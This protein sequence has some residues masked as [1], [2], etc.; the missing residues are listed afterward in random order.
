MSL[1]DWRWC[2]CESEVVWDR[3]GV[4]SGVAL[5]SSLEVVFWADVNIRDR[6]ER[7]QIWCD[8]QRAPS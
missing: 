6:C 7:A 1:E 2:E 4:G 3:A 5:V 8:L